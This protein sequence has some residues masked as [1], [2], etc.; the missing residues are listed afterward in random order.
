MTVPACLQE[1]GHEQ[2]DVR[3]DKEH[4]GLNNLPR[5]RLLITMDLHH[6][7]DGAVRAWS[8][9]SSGTVFSLKKARSS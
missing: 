3:S 7:M 2:E 9:L 8:I 4:T 1:E 6:P 5:T